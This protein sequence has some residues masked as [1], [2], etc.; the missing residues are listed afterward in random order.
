MIPFEKAYELVMAAARPLDTERVPL[1]GALNRVLAEDAV[2][3]MDM[4]PFDKSAMD[5]YACR[6]ADLDEALRVIET[7]PAG[8]M[9]TRNIAPGECAKIMTGAPVPEG[10]DCVIMIERSETAGAG[11]VR[12]TGTSTPANICIRGEDVRAGQIVLRQGTLIHPQHIAVLAAVGCIEPQVYRRARV[13]VIAT[14]DELVEP[15]SKPG[16]AKIRNSNSAQLM[17]QTTAAGAVPSYYGIASDSHRATLD[18]LHGALEENDV[19][20]ISGGVS[21]GDFDVVPEVITALGLEIAFDAIAI[22]PGKPTTFAAGDLGYC[23][24]LPGNPVSTYV[25]FEVLVKPFLRKLM[26]ESTSKSETWP[27]KLSAPIT[28]KGGERA[29]WIPVRFTGD[30]EA[31]PCDYHGSAHIHALCGADGLIFLPIGVTVLEKGAEAHVRP[32]RP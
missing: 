18:L 7:I 17:A 25:L 14:G 12:F 29:A 11:L 10:A 19:A 5:G 27:V 13:G 15:S 4:P 28:R 8:S 32:L 31:A 6:K 26:G 24:G 21:A 20:L 22:K 30:G 16:G 23:F 1:A 2:S 3:D 9:P